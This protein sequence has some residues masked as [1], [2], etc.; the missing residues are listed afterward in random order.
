VTRP[1]VFVDLDPLEGERPG[2]VEV[3]VVEAPALGVLLRVGA[4]EQPVRV[5]M[6]RVVLDGLLEELARLEQVFV[7]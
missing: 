2:T 7:V 6:G 3:T 1:G 5:R 4:G